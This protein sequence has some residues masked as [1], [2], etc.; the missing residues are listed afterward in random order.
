MEEPF[1]RIGKIYRLDDILEGYNDF[2]KLGRLY[3]DL[4]KKVLKEEPIMKSPEKVTT[5]ED[6]VR[7]YRYGWKLFETK[8]SFEDSL[9]MVEYKGSWS[10]FASEQK[11]PPSPE[12]AYISKLSIALID[13]NEELEE[14][15]ED[16]ISRYPR[17]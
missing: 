9:V 16:I 4:G 13:S 6:T 1:G 17:M 8:D 14:K 15:I 12:D 3:N 2:E 11:N 10:G 5:I 7:G